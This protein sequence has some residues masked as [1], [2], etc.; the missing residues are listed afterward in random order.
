MSHDM[1]CY[2]QEQ[3]TRHALHN[4]DVNATEKVSAARY[5]RIAG[6]VPVS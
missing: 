1:D 3:K 2:I 5:Y 4:R 6:G